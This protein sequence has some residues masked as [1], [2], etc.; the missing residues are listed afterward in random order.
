MLVC[1]EL[2][3]YFTVLRHRMKSETELAIKCIQHF[4]TE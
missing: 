3:K 4:R 1:I 2:Y